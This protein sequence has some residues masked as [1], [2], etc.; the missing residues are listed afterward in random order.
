MI[1]SEKVDKVTVFSFLDIKSLDAPKAFRIKGEF[2][3]LIT[4]PGIK[5]VVDLAG[6]D[7]IDSSGISVLLS[8]LRQVKSL[9]GRM[10]LCNLSANIFDLFMLLRLEHVFDIYVDRDKAIDGFAVIG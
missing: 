7:F 1:H 6:V 10:K 4:E 2:R 8:V 5:M 3:A 9:E